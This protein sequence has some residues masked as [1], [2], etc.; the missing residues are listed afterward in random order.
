[1]DG[2]LDGLLHAAKPPVAA[3]TPE[4]RQTMSAVLRDAEQVARPRRARRRGLKIA[5]AVAGAAAL[6]L[7]AAAAE[8]VGGILPHPADGNDWDND[9]SAV[10]LTVSLPDGA[11]CRAVYMVAPVETEALKHGGEQWQAVWK[12]ATTYLA[13]VDPHSLMSD[14][15]LQRYRTAARQEHAR[16]VASEPRSEVAPMP[17][18]AEVRVEAPGAELKSRLDGELERHHMPTDMLMMTSGDDCDPKDMQ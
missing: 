3:R 15:V 18:E 14:E 5:G 17:T 9:P 6:A 11:T 8:G 13:T 16:E 12:T 2:D 7:G 4:L 1:M 10:H